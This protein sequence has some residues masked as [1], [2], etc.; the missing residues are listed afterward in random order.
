MMYRI[1]EVKDMISTNDYRLALNYMI[2]FSMNSHLSKALKE[3]KF[4]HFLNVDHFFMAMDN[5]D[6]DQKSLKEILKNVGIKNVLKRINKMSEKRRQKKLKHLQKIEPN[7]KEMMKII[8]PSLK[9]Q[10]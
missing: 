3:K 5:I 1:E 8:N 10:L 7:I 2:I 9:M 6:I 4:L